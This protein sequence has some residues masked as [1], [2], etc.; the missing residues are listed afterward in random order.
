MLSCPAF[1]ALHAPPCVTA[2]VVSMRRPFLSL[3]ILSDADTHTH[4]RTASFASGRWPPASSTS[5]SSSTPRSRARRLCAWLS[6]PQR[7]EIQGV[8]EW[9]LAW[10]TPDRGD[11]LSGGRRDLRGAHVRVLRQHA[12]Q[13]AGRL[14]QRGG[15][16]LQ[17]QQRLSDQHLLHRS[18]P[19]LVPCKHDAEHDGVKL[20]AT[21]VKAA[22]LCGGRAVRSRDADK[23]AR[24]VA[25]GDREP[26]R[27]RASQHVPGALPSCQHTA[28]CQ[29][30]SSR[31]VH[32]AIYCLH[33]ANADVYGS[34]LTFMA[35]TLTFMATTLTFMAAT[36]TFMATTLTF[37]AVMLRQR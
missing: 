10:S 37:M 33:A 34:T 18:A 20:S 17:L 31:L 4:T 32:L 15:A 5:S 16:Q 13:A 22:I 35:A 26:E 2:L 1:L 23:A 7:R 3:A 21:A 25:R 6:E 30:I 27:H 9:M 11:C 8:I 19:A 12:P 36:L 24:G 28:V 29:R 14:L